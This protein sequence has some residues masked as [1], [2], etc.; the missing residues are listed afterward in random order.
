M[1]V[2][3]FCLLIYVDQG[4]IASNGINGIASHGTINGRGI[5]KIIIMGDFN[6]TN[7]QDGFLGSSYLIGFVV[8]TFVVAI[9]TSR[10]TGFGQ[11]P[12]IILGAPIISD[13]APHL[14]EAMWISIYYSFTTPGFAF[15]YIYGGLIGKYL[16]WRYAF[17]IL[18]L[19]MFPLFILSL[20][21]KG[22][23]DMDICYDDND[24]HAT[25]KKENK[26]F[27]AQIILK[28]VRIFQDMKLIFNKNFLLNNLGLIFYTFVLGAYSFW[29]PKA[30]YVL[31]EM[32]NADNIFGGMTLLCGVAGTLFGGWI[33]S[34]TGNSINYAFKI[35]SFSTYL[36]T[37]LCLGAFFTTNRILFIGLF[38][39]GE[40]ALFVVQGATYYT[41]LHCVPPHT[42][43]TAMFVSQ[44]IIHTLGDVISFPLVGHIL[45]WTHNWRTTCIIL[46]SVLFL[47]A[48]CWTIGIFVSKENIN[49]ESMESTSEGQITSSSSSVSLVNL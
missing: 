15:G 18:S 41:S 48:I 26:N 22:P 47:A 42:K 11:G 34:Y 24:T 35:Q 40:V 37:F 19:F 27:L 12:L 23:R 2:C 3:F 30:G 16:N 44:L 45:D 7:S 36:G 1:N 17:R 4:T 29:G 21:I 6:L 43:S 39:M 33:L 28:V 31:Y 14:K 20:L 13:I 5:H 8:S 38:S 49:E 10:L 9:L 46:T 32:N 25:R